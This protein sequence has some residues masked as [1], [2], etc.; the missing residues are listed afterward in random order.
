[1][2]AVEKNRAFT[3]YRHLGVRKT[4]MAIRKKK[5]GP[6]KQIRLY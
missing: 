3:G 1:M 2:Q 5:A 4:L 6:E